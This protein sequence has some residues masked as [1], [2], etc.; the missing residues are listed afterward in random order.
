VLF[1]HEEQKVRNM[2]IPKDDDSMEEH[3]WQLEAHQRTPGLTFG[4]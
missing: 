2:E 3:L 4:A 1:S